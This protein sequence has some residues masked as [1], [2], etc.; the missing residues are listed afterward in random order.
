MRYKKVYDE[1]ILGNK[2][3]EFRLLNDK[4]EKIKMGNLIKFKVIDK[5]RFVGSD[6]ML[7]T[8]SHSSCNVEKYRRVAISGNRGKDANFIGECYPALAPKLSFWKIWHDNIGVLTDEENNRYYIREY[9]KQVLSKLEP[10]TVSRD[11]DGAILLCYE[12]NNLFCHRHIV[13][14]WLEIMLGKV[15]PEVVIIDGCLVEV[16]RPIYIKDYLKEIMLLD[17]KDNEKKLIMARKNRD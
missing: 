8:G 3:V 11:L 14:A 17:E 6:K 1:M 16:T 2:T 5:N 9:Y 13:A 4:T 12:D 10:E 7:Y 15:V